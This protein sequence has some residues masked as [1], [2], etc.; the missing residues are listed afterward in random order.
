MKSTDL[1]WEGDETSTV[2]AEEGSTPAAEESAPLPQAET[3]APAVEATLL[4]ASIVEGEYTAQTQ[5]SSRSSRGRQGR[6][7]HMSS[8][9]RGRSRGKHVTTR[10]GKYRTIA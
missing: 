9:D 8:I 6:L 4:E 2:V 7:I 5:S 3:E 1:S 10:P